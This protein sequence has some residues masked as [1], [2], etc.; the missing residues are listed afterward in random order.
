MQERLTTPQVCAMLG[1]T[2][3]TILN[4][5]KGTSTK[6]PLPVLKP[7]KDEAPNAVR[8]DR[9]KVLAWAVKNGVEVVTKAPPRSLSQRG[10]KP[11]TKK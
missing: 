7:A 6:K 3:L 11:K 1:V 5:R 4:W 8:F 9:E 10:P 2:H